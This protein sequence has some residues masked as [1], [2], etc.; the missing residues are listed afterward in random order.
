MYYWYGIKQLDEMKAIKKLNPITTKCILDMAKDKEGNIWVGTDGSGLYRV[1]TKEYSDWKQEDFEVLIIQELKDKIIKAVFIDVYNQ[2][3]VA[4]NQGAYKVS[5]SEKNEVKV[6]RYSIAQGLPTNEVNC[7]YVDS[8]FAYIGT[9]K[10]LCR[11]PVGKPVFVQAKAYTTKNIIAPLNIRVKINGQ[12]T[13]FIKEA[14][15]PYDKNNLRFEFVCLSYKSDKNIMYYFRLNKNGEETEWQTTTEI[16]KE[17]PL[18]S[19]GDYIF[20]VKAIDIDGNEMPIKQITFHISPPFW[21]NNVFRFAIFVYIFDRSIF[22][23]SLANKRSQKNKYIRK[24]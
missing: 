12:D 4:T 23:L 6:K 20:E 9:T 11:V 3:W 7:L 21:R 1:K 13:T 5:V 14:I 24:T 22:N 18:L 19:E 16:Y 8:L 2:A 10:G 17:F 15:L